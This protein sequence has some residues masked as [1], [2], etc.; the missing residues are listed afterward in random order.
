MAISL[1]KTKRNSLTGFFI[2]IFISILSL[3]F[4]GILW[5]LLI[6]PLT[7]KNKEINVKLNSISRIDKKEISNL[8]ST[9]DSLNQEKDKLINDIEVSRSKLSL[10]KDISTLLDKFILT[11]KKRNL[12]FT[13][14]KPLP[15]QETILEN[16]ETKLFVKETPIIIELESGFSEFIQFLWDIEHSEELFKIKKLTI[17]INPK[18]ALRHKQSLTLSVY[19]LLDQV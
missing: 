11:A 12:E 10:K 1:D 8:M 3:A 5:V 15:K 18:N 13:Y 17:K 9:K 7:I 16:E 4:F 6:N 2:N 19:Q 14:I